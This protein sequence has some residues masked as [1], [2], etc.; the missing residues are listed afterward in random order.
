MKFHRPLLSFGFIFLFSFSL[1]AQTQQPLRSAFQPALVTNKIRYGDNA[2]AGRYAN[3]RDAKIYYEIYG[4][5]QPIVLLHGGLFGSTIEY[6]DIIQR[7]QTKYQVIAI[8]TRGHGKSELGKSPLSLD[9]RVEDAMAVINQVTPLKVMVIG[10]SDGGYTAYQL[11]AKYPERIQRM[12]V[13]GA[14]VLQPGQRKF[15]MTVQ[16]AMAL[17]KAYFEQQLKL[18]PE[19]HRLEEVFQSVAN[20]YSRLQ[21]DKKLLSKIQCP[22]MLMSGDSDEGNPVERIVEAANAIRQKELCIIPNTGHVCFQENPEAAWA[23]IRPFIEAADPAPI[24]I[25]KENYLPSKVHLEVSEINNEHILRLTKHDSVKMVDEPTFAIVKDMQFQNGIIEVKVLSRL[26]PTA[27][28]FAR[29]FIGVAFRINEDRSK[30]ECLYIRPSNGRAAQQV[31]RNHSTQYFS[32]PDYKFDRLR[33][34]SPEVYESYADMALEEWIDLKIVVQDAKAYLYVNH[35]PHP[36]L[37]VN[38]LKHGIGMPG[39]VG[40]WVEVGTEGFFKDL[41]I[42]KR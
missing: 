40:L 19:P 29:G 42:T 9:Q 8:S 1:N 35:D 21:M 32:Y 22:V 7:L 33:K 12:V 30:F 25:N 4:S 16:K 10:F 27:S 28:E 36:A 37:V 20:Y 3:A 6:A 15:D 5:G 31:R 38:D 13:I 11:A 14:G 23:C 24:P 2:A 34:E 18:M 41:R 17:D 39:S 26:L